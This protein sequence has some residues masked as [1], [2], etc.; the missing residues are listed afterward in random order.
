M[1]VKKISTK[2]LVFLMLINVALVFFGCAN[3]QAITV[4][5]SDGS[6]DERVYVTIDSNEVLKAGYDLEE[7]KDEI[8]LNSINQS[9]AFK[10]D[11]N[12]RVQSDLLKV[13]D[14]D[15]VKTLTGYFNG[16]D[17]ISTTWENNKLMVGIR[18]K[19]IDVYRYYY[20]I[21]KNSTSEPEVEEHFF[22][23]KV[24]YY[25]H[26]MFL[27]HF[28]LYD[29]LNNYYLTKYN[30]LAQVETNKLIYTYETDL[31]REHSDADYVIYQDGKYYHS[32]V[33]EPNNI[34]KVVT[35]Y[36]NIA[37]PENWILVSLGASFGVSLIILIIGLILKK[38]NKNK[39]IT[40]N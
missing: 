3:V 10:D 30:A 9:K 20:Q 18:F 12:N 16:I 8:Y 11:L 33:V 1:M 35:L 34:D 5:N 39:K 36:Y 27:K 15:S 6:I 38:L 17:V 26:T 21:P 4:F 25:G 2:L 37:N 40:K 14:D 22:Y 13:D 19:N 32:W 29:S 7:M 24:S 28:A 31:R 23:N